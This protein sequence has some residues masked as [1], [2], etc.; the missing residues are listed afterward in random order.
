MY[1]GRVGYEKIPQPYLKNLELD[2]LKSLHHAK[3]SSIKSRTLGTGT[4]DN[5]LPQT[6]KMKHLK[7][8]QKKKQ[9]RRERDGEIMR[10]N[11]L[12]LRKMTKI[13]TTSG[14]G[15]G[16]ENS[17][18][19]RPKKSLNAIRRSQELARIS[20]AN[21]QI[22]ARMLS[23][24][25]DHD[26]KQ[27]LQDSIH[28]DKI[29]NRLRMVKYEGDESSISEVSK[30]GLRK[31]NDEIRESEEVESTLSGS[32]TT[33]WAS[34]GSKNVTKNNI[35][36]IPEAIMGPETK[37]EKKEMVSVD[38]NRADGQPSS[39]PSL[40]KG[41]S[42]PS[43]L[44]PNTR[45]VNAHED[46][47][48]IGS[49][50][51]KDV[52]ALSAKNLNRERVEGSKEPPKANADLR[53]RFTRQMSSIM[54][55]KGEFHLLKQNKGVT[56][57]RNGHAEAR[58][59]AS[60]DIIKKRNGKIRIHVTSKKIHE[61]NNIHLDCWVDL[62]V[63][64][65]RE[66]LDVKNAHLIGEDGEEEINATR[67]ELLDLAWGLLDYANVTFDDD[68]R[69]SVKFI[70]PKLI[71]EHSVAVGSGNRNVIHDV[72]KEED[73]DED[74]SDNND[75][76]NNVNDKILERLL[77]LNYSD[78]LIKDQGE[79]AVGQD[80]ENDTRERRASV[81][82]HLGKLDTT[83]APEREYRKSLEEDSCVVSRPSTSA[84]INEKINRKFR[85]RCNVIDA[86]D[87][88]DDIEIEPVEC[89]VSFSNQ[90]KGR[91]IDIAAKPV[92]D[93]VK[94]RGVE[95]VLS[96]TSIRVPSLVS[97]DIEATET[98]IETLS[99]NV[100]FKINE[101]DIITGEKVVKLVMNHGEGS[102]A[103]PS[104]PHSRV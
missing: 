64:G 57:L 33:E 8:R 6:S 56:I 51:M 54:P 50:A 66:V 22:L 91:I 87:K 31:L 78:S 4:L 76:E 10:G 59:Q 45:K 14:S 44:S 32:I 77:A 52:K 46:L 27:L 90:R 29:V 94:V 19:V 49:A 70:N 15:G 98:Y 41:Q 43:I 65:A 21:K 96:R 100:S 79:G 53:K 13:I 68:D 25:S 39:P 37:K 99:N 5:T 18:N 12:L 85:V 20:H 7:L 35:T 69:M 34:R 36:K 88:G 11:K 28:H 1:R 82:K 42:A 48:Q 40:K 67:N 93:A 97:V 9:M 89:D 71:A 61:V 24:K 81:R 62:G 95:L 17:P 104:R 73:D 63:K 23:V 75:S 102:S 30:R 92:A 101:E 58:C 83:D 26:V 38:S 72:L 60:V 74:D 86:L 84:E 3:I 47:K 2:R 16:G 55:S 103:S 80:G